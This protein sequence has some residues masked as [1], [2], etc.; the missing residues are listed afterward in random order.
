MEARDGPTEGEMDQV[1]E[2]KDGVYFSFKIQS[3]LCVC[4][5]IISGA[6]HCLMLVQTIQ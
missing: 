5:A 3:C 4:A 1:T 6:G 2:K